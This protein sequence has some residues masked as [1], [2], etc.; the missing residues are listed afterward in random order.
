MKNMLFFVSEY[1]ELHWLHNVIEA[2]NG[3]VYTN[4]DECRKYCEK[5]NFKVVADRESYKTIVVTNVHLGQQNEIV[6]YF[7]S[8]GGKAVVIQHGWDPAIS[9]YD[10]FWNEDVGRFSYYL[11]GCQQD[12]EWLTAKYGNDRIIMTGIPKLDDVY[13][14]KNNDVDL[15][16]IYESVGSSQ[17]YI[18]NAPTDVFSVDI[19]KQYCNPLLERSPYKI[20][21][22]THPG[23]NMVLHF[24][25][26]TYS[27]DKYTMVNDD[28][29]DRNYVYKLIKASRG[30]VIIE[31]FLIMEASF[32]E[33]PAI[34]WAHD[35]LPRDLYNKPE[36]VNQIHRLPVEMSSTFENPE[37]KPMQKVMVDKYLFDGQNTQRVV[38]FLKGLYNTL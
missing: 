12:Y 23:F 31:S 36:N 4:S 20:V 34:F 19:H 17:F 25:D 16:S 6:K 2:M 21:Y 22:K 28:H 32:L 14:I 11:V 10:N 15:T 35:L 27:S 29:F 7:M 24:P 38:T 13:N 3:D 18:A 37:Y 8:T 1:W 33:K 30:V 5:F 9:L 26:I